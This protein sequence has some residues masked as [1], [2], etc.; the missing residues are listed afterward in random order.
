MPGMD[1]SDTI[2]T[3]DGTFIDIED[4]PKNT[5][6][7]QLY[8]RWKVADDNRAAVFVP[9]EKYQR[10]ERELQT[11]YEDADIQNTSPEEFAR[12]VAELELTKRTVRKLAPEELRLGSN[13]RNTGIA[14]G[15]LQGELSDDV[16]TYLNKR[17]GMLTATHERLRRK[18]L[19][20]YSADAL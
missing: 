15:K 16:N 17:Q 2:K 20:Y 12:I 6:I 9:L 10:R 19:A 5:P 18:I 1:F 4:V 11:M 7:G 8:R 3:I 13:A 14:L